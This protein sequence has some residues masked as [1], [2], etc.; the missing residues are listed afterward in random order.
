MPRK[1][2]KDPFSLFVLLSRVEFGK[3][4]PSLAQGFVGGSLASFSAILL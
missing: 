3:P 2:W 1:E 4:E